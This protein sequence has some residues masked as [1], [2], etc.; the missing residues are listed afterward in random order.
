LQQARVPALPASSPL[1][2]CCCGT[3]SISCCCSS[4]G[5]KHALPASIGRSPCCKPY[6]AVLPQAFCAHPAA[7]SILLCGW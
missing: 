2:A 5:V 4:Q 7:A 6:A 3:A 1:Q